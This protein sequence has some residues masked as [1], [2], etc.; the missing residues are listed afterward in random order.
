CHGGKATVT[1]V[2]AMNVREPLLDRTQ[3]VALAG[4]MLLGAAF[5]YSATM[6]NEAAASGPLLSQ[7]WVRQIIWYGMGIGAGAVLCLADYRSMARWSFVIY[8][9]SILLLIAVLIP[10]IGSMRFGARRWI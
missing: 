9:I 4:L 8:W 5:V 10:A 7:S 2:A 3:L 6:V 1:D